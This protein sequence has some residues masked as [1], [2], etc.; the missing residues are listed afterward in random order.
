MIKTHA[1]SAICATLLACGILID[2]QASVFKGGTHDGFSVVRV[3]SI[4]GHPQIQNALGATNV[5]PSSAWLNGM[6]LHAGGTAQAE[7]TVYWGISDGG[8][9]P[10][11][12][13]TPLSL[14][15]VDPFDPLSVQIV[16][17][18]GKSYF[19]RFFAS[20]TLGETGWA[21]ASATFESPSPAAVSTG[22]GAAV[23][24]VA[25]D[26]NGELTDGVEAEMWLDWG[27]ADPDVPPV[28]VTTVDLGIRFIPGTSGI[29]NPFRVRIAGLTAATG[30]AYRIR[31]ENVSGAV[32]SDW[33]WF[34]TRPADFDPEPEPAGF[35]GGSRDGYA[36]KTLMGLEM[37]GW[38]EAKLMIL[39]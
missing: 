18:P 19:Y 35:T 21:M 31:A 28:G 22:A 36:L 23:G 24:I 38:G 34:S 10:M 13:D 15:L 20:N 16:I 29:P 14:G 7:V 32:A 3:A 17:E 33:V 27:A 39:R 5:T 4:P 12:W 11:E 25:A 9:D 26:L 6:L 37:P 2:G 8:T 1:V 30:Y